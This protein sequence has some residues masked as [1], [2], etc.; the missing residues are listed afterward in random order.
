[1][2]RTLQVEDDLD[3]TAERRELDR[4]NHL[5]ATLRISQPYMVFCSIMS[6]LSLVLLAYTAWKLAQYGIDGLKLHTDP[7]EET[8][9]L[10]VCAGIAAE[11]LWALR[12]LPLR[13]LCRARLMQLDLLVFAMA[14]MSAMLASANLTEYVLEDRMAEG[15]P[16]EL[17]RSATASLFLFRFLLQPVRTILSTRNVLRLTEE[18][19]VA[20][21]DITLPPP[22]DM[23]SLF[24]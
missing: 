11:A 8:F 13:L 9:E 10:F 1:M 24:A 15:E 5:I 6:A 4:A 3:C 17:W 7:V 19:K 18:R 23:P 14:S 16:E 22:V 2:L 20:M 12:V 21:E